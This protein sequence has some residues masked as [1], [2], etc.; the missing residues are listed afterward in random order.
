MYLHSKFSLS[1]YIIR[2]RGGEVRWKSLYN[3]NFD[4]IFLLTYSLD[5]LG[6][7]PPSSI[8]ISERVHTIQHIIASS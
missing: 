2:Q 1:Y 6:K 4:Y 8:I 5:T 3:K 7:P